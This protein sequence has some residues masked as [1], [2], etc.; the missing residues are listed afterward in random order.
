MAPGLQLYD[1]LTVITVETNLPRHR[2]AGDALA[3][4]SAAACFFYQE[5]AAAGF[6]AS[7]KM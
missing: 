2:S 1:W 7:T 6:L 5:G 3:F 4:E